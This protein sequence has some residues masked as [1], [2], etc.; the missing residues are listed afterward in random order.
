VGRWHQDLVP[1]TAA[2]KQQAIRFIENQN[3]QASTSTFNA[4]EAALAYDIEAIY[5]LT[6]GAPTSGKI[7]AP[8]DIIHTVIDGN[9]LRRISIYTI[10][11]AP[12]YSGSPTD[13][14]LKSL[15][16]EN[17]GTYRRVDG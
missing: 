12:G 9:R 10:G 17:L 7:L 4:L 1:A 15:A 5:F 16:E 13:Q 2:N 14:F 11:I 6:D 3:P 8:A